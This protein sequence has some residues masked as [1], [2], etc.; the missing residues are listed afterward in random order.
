MLGVFGSAD[1][2]FPA[3]MVEEFR[4]ALSE[5]GVSNQVSVYAGEG[6]AFW[7]DMDQVG[8]N[9]EG[10]QARAWLELTTFLREAL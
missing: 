5:A 6:H 2:Q 4:T 10:P 8:E 9:P 7:R 1:A 3:R